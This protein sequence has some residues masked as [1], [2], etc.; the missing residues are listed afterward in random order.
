MIYF[1]DASPLFQ[2]EPTRIITS[3]VG[4]RQIS[5]EGNYM[6]LSYRELIDIYSI[7]SLYVST[8]K[9]R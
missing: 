7:D 4:T 6:E 3:E 2:I 8:G 9:T 1:P 5:R